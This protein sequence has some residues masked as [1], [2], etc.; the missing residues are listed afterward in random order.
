MI[1]HAA[2]EAT[3]ETPASV[4]LVG[5]DN[6]TV[7]RVIGKILEKEGHHIHYAATGPAALDALLTLR[8]DLALLDADLPDL[9]AKEVTQLYR[10]RARGGQH[11][12]ILGLIGEMSGAALAAWMET[13]LDGCVGKPIEP[14]E[15]LDAVNSCLEKAPPQ[16][17]SSLAEKASQAASIDP[18]V[19]CD[20]ENLGGEEFVDDVIAQFTAD[21]VRI[22]PVLEDSAEAGDTSA[23]RDQ[24]H[25]LRSCAGN[26]GATGVYKLCL[27]SQT[28]APSELVGTGSTFV[29]RLRSELERA[30]DDLSARAWRS[31]A[32]PLAKAG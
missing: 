4:I 5:E 24:I 16:P 2:N 11:L 26:V 7:G 31:A 3:T 13:G 19:L 22:L 1:P 20:L 30:S 18:R 10:C 21:A 8:L 6:H 9:D 23:F 27:A 14:I 17:Q 28:M 29:A 32:P 12:P 15:L 25:A